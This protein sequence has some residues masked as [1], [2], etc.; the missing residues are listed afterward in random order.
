[1]SEKLEKYRKRALRRFL[2][3]RSKNEYIAARDQQQ[4]FFVWLRIHVLYCWCNFRYPLKPQRYYRLGVKTLARF[5]A[6]AL[7]EAG[8]RPLDRAA[9]HRVV[10]LALQQIRRGRVYLGVREILK[11][12]ELAKIHFLG[13]IEERYELSP[14]S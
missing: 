9:L 14:I 13:F 5:A 2:S 7:Q 4:Q 12:P 11:N 8:Y 1:L 6:E 10:R 3:S